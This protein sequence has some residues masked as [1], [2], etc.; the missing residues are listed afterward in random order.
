MLIM[1]LNWGTVEKFASLDWSGELGL[2]RLTTP[3]GGSSYLRGY[4]AFMA[5][6]CVLPYLEENLRCLRATLRSRTPQA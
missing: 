4:L 6:L 2:H 3:P 1:V 5:V